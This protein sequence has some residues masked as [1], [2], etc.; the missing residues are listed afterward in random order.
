MS[1]NIEK[2]ISVA[3][4]EIKT[5]DDKSWVELTDGD[6][7]KHCVFPAI[8][9][10]DGAWVH[11]DKEIDMLERKILNGS[12]EGLALELTKER[13]GQYWNVTGVKAVEN[14][15]KEKAVKEVAD[16]QNETRNKSIAL[17]Y[18]KD[19]AVANLIECSQTS[20]TQWADF[21]YQY[22]IGDK[23]SGVKTPIEI[24][25]PEAMEPG[26]TNQQE[27][28]EATK[29]SE[30]KTIQELMQWAQKKGKAITPSWVCKQ[31]NIQAPTEI[32]DVHKA[33]L[34]LKELIE[35]HRL[36]QRIEP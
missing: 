18:S 29:E 22:M 13:E 26:Q 28:L 1:R 35:T 30:P 19:L 31:L 33:Y 36:R 8:L 24:V 14:I 2:I 11:L 16:T 25:N 10:N 4:G 5:K 32:Q 12:I 20:L 7:K 23:I 15:F 27:I 9:R 3:K 17:S 21:F 6:D 34:A